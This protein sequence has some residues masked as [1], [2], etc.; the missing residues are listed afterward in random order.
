MSLSLSSL[1]GIYV[2]KAGFALTGISPVEISLYSGKKELQLF[3]LFFFYFIFFGGGGGG[4]WMYAS[5]CVLDIFN[6]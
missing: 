1:C 6:C 2:Y 5:F 3:R 4:S